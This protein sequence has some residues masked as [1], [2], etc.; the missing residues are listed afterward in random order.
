[1]LAARMSR[2]LRSSL[3]R[4]L[5]AGARPPPAI[6]GASAREAS[7]GDAAAACL[8]EL[9]FP[10]SATRGRR[11]A[12]FERQAPSALSQLQCP[13]AASRG[14]CGDEERGHHGAG[15]APQ[16]DHR[17]G[18][19][20]RLPCNGEEEAPGDPPGQ[21]HKE[22]GRLHGW[23]NQEHR[24]RRH[25]SHRGQSQRAGTPAFTSM[26]VAATGVAFCYSKNHTS[27]GEEPHWHYWD[28]GG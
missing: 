16:E 8:T 5:A 14:R 25:R 23:P 18:W 2:P 10:H 19:L 15:T 21:L 6:R 24:R 3:A 27:K 7:R 9:Q 22:P 1:M 4:Y 26:A 12:A 11:E 28:Q 13:R 20:P 17:D